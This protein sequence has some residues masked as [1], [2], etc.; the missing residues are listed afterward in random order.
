MYSNYSGN[1]NHH[2]GH[3]CL[4]KKSILKPKLKPKPTTTPPLLLLLIIIIALIVI[5]NGYSTIIIV[6]TV[7]MKEV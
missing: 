7:R 6:I 3:E 4:S 2:H 5:I 1:Q